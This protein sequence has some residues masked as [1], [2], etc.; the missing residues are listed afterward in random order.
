MSHIK[1]FYFFIRE[2]A[3]KIISLFYPE[4]CIICGEGSE[5]LLFLCRKCVGEIRLFED[6]KFCRKCL[7]QLPPYSD[8]DRCGKCAGMHFDKV[9]ALIVFDDKSRMLFHEIKFLKNYNAIKL[10]D[11]FLDRFKNSVREDF[12]SFFIV[13]VP[14]ALNRK[15]KRGFN[16]SALFAKMVSKKYKIPVLRNKLVRKH[17]GRP[18]SILRRNERM[19]NIYGQFYCRGRREISGKNIILVDDIF[20]TGATADECARVLKEAGAKKVVIIVMGR[21]L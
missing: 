18:Q 14:I 11:I 10:F 12:S 4:V 8:K 6:G 21:T 16:Q 5:D 20:T 1:K 13:P 15:L 19:K 7:A 17:L 2:K 3:R 9:Y